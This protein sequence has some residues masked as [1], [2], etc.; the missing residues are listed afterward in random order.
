MFGTAESISREQR[1]QAKRELIP[2]G[3]AL[4]LHPHISKLQ[5][6]SVSVLGLTNRPLRIMHYRA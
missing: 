4:E 5:A 2:L 3:D 6:D 1:I